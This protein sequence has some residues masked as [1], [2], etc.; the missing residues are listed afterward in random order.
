MRREQ[1]TE[2]HYIA[3]VDN[4]ESICSNG[5]LSHRRAR[6]LAH[7]D[8]SMAEV[9]DLR[10]GKRVPGGLLLHD[11]ANLYVTARNPMLFKRI[12]DGWLDELCVMRISADVLDLDDVVVTDRNA[13]KFG[14]RFKSPDEGVEAIDEALLSRTYWNDCDSPLER[15]RCWNTKFTEV[16]VPQGVSPELLRGIYLGSRAALRT[17]S[18]RGLPISAS[19]NADL[20]FNP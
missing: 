8:I 1:L 19:R 14:C 16:L 7:M 2:L 10:K 6:R 20:F 5:V 18:A 4:V 15:D 9:Q 13:A 17:V 12:R 11:Y 3:H